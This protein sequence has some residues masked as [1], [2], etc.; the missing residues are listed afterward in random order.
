MLV[1]KAED[2]KKAKE[3]LDNLGIDY[4]AFTTGFVYVEQEAGLLHI[5]TDCYTEEEV[6]N[7][8]R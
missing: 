3:R 1:L 7:I 5:D 8:I 4:V 6:K 2:L